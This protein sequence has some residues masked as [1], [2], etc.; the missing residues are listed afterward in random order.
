MMIYMGNNR[1][2]TKAFQNHFWGR[3]EWKE[4]E[5]LFESEENN[6]S[7]ILEKRFEYCLCWYIRHACKLK[8]VFYSMT[9][10]G[11]ICPLVSAVI[12]TYLLNISTGLIINWIIGILSIVSGLS[13]IILNVLRAQEKWT[14]YREAVEFLKRQRTKYRLE[15]SGLDKSH[16]Y[17]LE[18]KYLDIIEN[19]MEEENNKWKISN[20]DQKNQNES[21]PTQKKKT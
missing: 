7:I 9:I 5:G 15:K 1:K 16:N 3:R 14:R 17:K 6:G 12:N 19:Y 4:I 21:A 8:F 13:V 10:L 11:A 18:K 20:M 2:Q